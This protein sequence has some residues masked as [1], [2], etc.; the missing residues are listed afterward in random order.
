MREMIYLDNAATTFPKPSTVVE[1]VKKCMQS[2]GGNPGRGAHS[3]SLAAAKKVFECRSELADMLKISKS[4]LN[5]RMRRLIA[6]AQED[7]AK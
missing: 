3:L 1:E 5:H 4:C 7:I 6:I 2:Y